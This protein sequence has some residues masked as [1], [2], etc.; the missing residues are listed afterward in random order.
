MDENR[1]AP[2]DID[3]IELEVSSEPTNHNRW[4]VYAIND[5]GER[6]LY[7]GMNFTDEDE[8]R[9]FS[10]LFTGWDPEGNDAWETVLPLMDCA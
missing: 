2:W 4:F 7:S 8:A 10:T 3:V 9:R 1:P 5:R 6:K